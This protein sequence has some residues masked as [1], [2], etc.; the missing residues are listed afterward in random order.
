MLNTV[1]VK[2]TSK[3]LMQYY[4]IFSALVVVYTAYRA[5]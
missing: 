4:I 2:K 3:K 5:L 1:T